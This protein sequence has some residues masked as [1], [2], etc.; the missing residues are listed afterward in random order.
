MKPIGCSWVAMY[1]Q[2]LCIDD[3]AVN[4]VFTCRVTCV[5][6]RINSYK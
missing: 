6:C 1:S 3:V 2:S 4:K 5:W